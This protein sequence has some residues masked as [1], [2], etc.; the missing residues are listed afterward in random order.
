MSRPNILLITADQL[1]SDAVACNKAA[2]N[3][4]ALAHHVRTPHLDQLAREGATFT[5]CHT[6]SPICV[7]ARAS[8]TTGNYP[9][10]CTGRKNNGGAILPGQPKLAEVFAAAGYRTCAIGKLHYLP[11]AKPGES[12]TLHGFQEAEL[13]EEGR[14]LSEFSAGG[15]GRGLEDYHDWLDEQGW[16]GFER[17]HNVGNNDAK[18]ASSPVPADLHEE[19]WVMVRTLA[20]LERHQAQANGKPLL[21]WTS[22]AKPHPPYDPPP[23]YDTMYDPRHMPG[24]VGGWD[25]EFGADR[26]A[27]L[28]RR[29]VEYG[30][31]RYAP[32][33][34]LASR[35]R[36]AGLITFQDHL[37]GKILVKL[38]SLGLAS[39]TIVLFT[40]DHGDLLGDFGRFFKT[41]FYDGAVK[42]PMIWRLPMR[43]AISHEPRAQLVGLQD[44]LPT[45]CS[46][47]GIPF[48]ETVD[49]RDLSPVLHDASAEVR[50]I[51]V[52]EAE[53]GGQKAMLRNARYKYIWTELGGREE[54]YDLETDPCELT[55]LAAVD[56]HQAPLAALRAKLIAWACDTKDTR[57]V[58]N[59]K[60][61]Q[62]PL[63]T[64]AGFKQG[65]LGW[66]RY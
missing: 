53:D 28:G 39:E 47:A 58:A 52:S 19:A 22:F 32:Q 63:L 37:I 66:R 38:E 43:V 35:A 27:E 24:P 62:K 54:L 34:V 16:S 42:V 5:N 15:E 30:W 12:R 56:A 41:C 6:P 23:P 11:Y 20:A 60:L 21:L 57:L 48:A 55:N 3:A 64:E 50:D 33:T 25:G 7:P 26:D 31:D 4:H 17:A 36:Y 18:P 40:S 2:A 14:I 10:R 29:R 13:N 45:L 59:G 61:A 9:H 49:G 44:V 8:L 51:I 1:R 46:L 65:N